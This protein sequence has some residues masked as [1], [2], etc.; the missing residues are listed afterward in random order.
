[1]KFLSYSLLLFLFFLISCSEKKSG[2]PFEKEISLH[3]KAATMRE[4]A[5]QFSEQVGVEFKLSEDFKPD[6]ILRD[7]FFLY[8]PEAKLKDHIAELKSMY[9]VDIRWEEDHFTMYDAPLK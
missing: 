8:F 2:P 9:I 7:E 5:L 4:A 6:E 1:M 3:I